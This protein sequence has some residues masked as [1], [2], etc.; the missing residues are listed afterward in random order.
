RILQEV[1]TQILFAVWKATLKGPGLCVEQ[2]RALV[3]SAHHRQHQAVGRFGPVA[4]VKI[5]NLQSIAERRGVA[6]QDAV[7]VSRA[8]IEHDA[9][10]VRSVL[11][12]ERGVVASFL[13]RCEPTTASTADGQGDHHESDESEHAIHVYLPA[14]LT[15]R[16]E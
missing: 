2:D 13:D 10:H 8:D 11:C 9:Q 3:A 14:S 12:L 1:V 16:Y 6:A 7:M 4:E 15:M 5:D